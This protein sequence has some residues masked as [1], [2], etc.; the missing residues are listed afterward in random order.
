MPAVFSTTRRTNQGW[1]YPL[2][3]PAPGAVDAIEQ[4][5]LGQVSFDWLMKTPPATEEEVARVKNLAMNNP[6]L[7]GTLVSE[8]MKAMG[9]YIPVSEKDFASQV[10]KRLLAKIEELN[11]DNGDK[12]Y[13]TGLP[14]AEDTFGEEMFVQM[15][16]SA[17]LA[18]LAIFLLV[19][20]ISLVLVKVGKGATSLCLNGRLV[21]IFSQVICYSLAIMKVFIQTLPL[22]TKTRLIV[23]LS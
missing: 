18:M 20:L 1:S 9:I 2:Q 4:A 5:G 3:N 10:R 13:I 14:V 6:L 15:A 21:L 11:A 8:D 16:V 12:F 23:F 22:R 17:P 7:K 19:S